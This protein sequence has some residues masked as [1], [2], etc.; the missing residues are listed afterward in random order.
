[1]DGRKLENIKKMCS[2]SAYVVHDIIKSFNR[3][4]VFKTYLIR[5]MMMTRVVFSCFYDYLF[6]ILKR[7]LLFGLYKLAL[8][9]KEVFLASREEMLE[10]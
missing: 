2:L 5:W 10:C 6:T 7:L 4:C 3:I 1:M 9:C 8:R